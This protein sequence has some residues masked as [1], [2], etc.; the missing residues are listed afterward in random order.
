MNYSL[1]AGEWNSVFAVP[2]GVVDKYIKLAS[3]NS[4]KLLLFLLRHGGTLFSDT[5]LKEKLGFRREGELEDAALFWVQRGIIRTDNG[6]LSAASD[7]EDVQETLPEVDAA[8]SMPTKP[9]RS[10][11][12]VISAQSGSIYTSGYVGSRLASEPEL[13]WLYSEAEKLYGRGLRQPESQTV[14]M[15]VEHFGLPAQ[16]AA[17]LLRYCFKIGKTTAGYIQTM[18]QSWSE[19]EINT[20]SAADERLAVLERRFTVEEQLRSAMELK[21]KF[22]SKQLGYIR[23]WSEDWGF[24]VDMILLAHE[25]T[26]DRTGSMNFDYTNKILENWNSAGISTK[27]AVEQDSAAHKA[28]VKSQPTKSGGKNSSI[29]VNSL[30]KDVLQKYH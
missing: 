27:E 15:L 8:A 12:K 7:D 21:T 24:S 5:E 2:S 23:T 13:K 22:S 26:Q 11:V 29:D 19:E 9:V 4:L 30:M 18:A 6:S 16:V 25:I 20:V 17:M 10:S 14:L 3:G 1:N 28:S